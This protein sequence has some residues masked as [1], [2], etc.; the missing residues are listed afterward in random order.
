MQKFRFKKK[1]NA[2][3][4]QIALREWNSEI[5]QRQKFAEHHKKYQNLDPFWQGSII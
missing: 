3:Y 2:I 4:H 1:T 5:H